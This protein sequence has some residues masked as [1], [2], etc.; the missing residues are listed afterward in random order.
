MH[1]MHH[2][3]SFWSLSIAQEVGCCCCCCLC[4]CNMCARACVCVIG[5]REAI[6]DDLAAFEPLGQ[7]SKRDY[8]Q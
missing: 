3:A 8:A 5:L 1:G 4:V 6:M 2:D 7:V